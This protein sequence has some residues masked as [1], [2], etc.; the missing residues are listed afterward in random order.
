METEYNREK[1]MDLI[2]DEVI[3]FGSAMVLVRIEP[4]YTLSYTLIPREVDE[5]ID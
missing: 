2:T 1:A 5:W 4:N 3:T